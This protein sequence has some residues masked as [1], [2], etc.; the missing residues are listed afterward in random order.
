MDFT[1]GEIYDRFTVKGAKLG[2]LANQIIRGLKRGHYCSESIGNTLAKTN[3]DRARQR[4]F[5][6]NLCPEGLAFLRQ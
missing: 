2:T 5:F 4:V 1:G 3:P 6:A